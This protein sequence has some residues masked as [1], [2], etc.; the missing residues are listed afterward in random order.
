MCLMLTTIRC[1]LF[2]EQGFA[3]LLLVI[4]FWYGLAR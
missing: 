2:V 4:G 3:L 1:L